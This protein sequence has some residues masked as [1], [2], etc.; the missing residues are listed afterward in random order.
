MDDGS[1]NDPLELAAEDTEAG[2]NIMTIKAHQNQ[3]VDARRDEATPDA[4][5]REITW[6][7]VTFIDP[8]DVAYPDWL[9]HALECIGANQGVVRVILER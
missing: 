5:E 6:T 9:A 7:H 8:D 2:S 4:N 3:G 1:P